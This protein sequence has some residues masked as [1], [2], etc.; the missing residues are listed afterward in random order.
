MENASMA[1]G[2]FKATCLSLMDEVAATGREIVITKRGKPVA[3]LVPV[4]PVQRPKSILGALAY[5]MTVPDAPLIVEGSGYTVADNQRKWDERLVAEKRRFSMPA[6][7]R[8]KAKKT[9]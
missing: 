8:G 1:A 3:K 4:T 5:M 2:E 7:R 9:L 6:Q